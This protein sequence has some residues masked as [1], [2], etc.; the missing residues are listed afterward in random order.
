MAG[1]HMK[2][3]HLS[4]SS[5]HRQA[6]L[7]NLVTSLFKHESIA[8]TW[9]KAKEAQR[10]AEKLVT[11]G[12]K[13]TEATRRRAH[14]I[15]YEP[16]EMVPKL[17]GPIR[18]RY[19]SRPGGYTRVLRIEPMKE[20]QAESAILEL[21]DG[22]KDMR[23]ALTAKTLARLPADRQFT[24]G[25]ASHVKKVTQFREDGVED[26]REMVERMRV[27]QD[28]GIDNRIL[29]APRKVYPEEK[30]KRDMHY[31]EDVD[32]YKLPN[33]LSKRKSGSK[34]EEQQQLEVDIVNE[35]P[36]KQLA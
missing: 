14:Q 5:S 28:N 22:P 18:E 36:S 9:H 24:P 10:L 33:A 30:M 23:F 13:N 26:L 4:R 8:T 15:F 6:L 29:P 35:E 20:D 7:R 12:K 25:V 31:F 21:V 16:N 27:E 19:A 17:F 32:N 3:R 1:G 11:L 34:Q 2:Y